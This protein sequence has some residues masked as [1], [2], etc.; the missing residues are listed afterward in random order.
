M[1]DR[2]EPKFS[3]V[4]RR[5]RLLTGLAVLVTFAVGLVGGYIG[6][7]QYHS[8]EGAYVGVLVGLLPMAVISTVLIIGSGIA[9]AR[10]G[11]VI[12]DESTQSDE[13]RPRRQ[14]K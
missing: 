4:T 2:E 11:E 1:T 12:G 6:Y 9:H 10:R 8:V 14:S 5:H 3:K 7:H 13:G